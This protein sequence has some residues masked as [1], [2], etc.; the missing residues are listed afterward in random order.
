MCMQKR[1]GL[2]EAWR[3]GAHALGLFHVFMRCR[4]DEN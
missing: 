3:G 2:V 4:D 1:R